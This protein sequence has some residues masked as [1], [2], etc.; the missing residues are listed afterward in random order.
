MPRKRPRRCSPTSPRKPASTF[1]HNSGASPDKHMFETF[2][3]GV[4]WI[5]YD[6][7]GFPDLY[8]VNGAPG[9]AN[10]LYHNNRDGTFTD[11]TAARRRRGTARRQ[12]RRTRPASPSATTTTT[13][14]SICMS[15]RS[16]R[17]SFSQQRRRHVHAT[18]PRRR[19][20]PAAPTSGARAPAS[21]T[22]IAT[23]I[24]ISTSPTTSTTASTRTRTAAC[25]KPG[26][27]MYCHPTHLRRHGGSA[28][29]QQRRRHVHRRLEAGRH[30][31]S[32]GQGARR[33]VLRFRSRRRRRHLRRER[34]WCGTSSIATTATAPSPTSPMRAGVGF[35]STA[36]RRPAW[37][38]TAPTSTATVFPTSSSR[39]SP[40]S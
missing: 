22:T 23:A 38:S 18:S 9:T 40:R 34:H 1:V 2:G 28:V 3:S 30:R 33:D 4:A 6:N 27:R 32:G 10:A 29:P 36:S 11:V 35:D 20:W 37:A 19:A 17:T 21:S 14:I 26:Y 12:P 25:A 15:P 24:S 13:A 16:V 39:T 5:D 8:F 7:D 31:Q